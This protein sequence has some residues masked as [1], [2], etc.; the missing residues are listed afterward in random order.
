MIQDWLNRGRR[1]GARPAL[2]DGLEDDWMEQPAQDQGDC[3]P[4][5]DAELQLSIVMPC[6]NEADTIAICI[7]KAQE[8]LREHHIH[9]EIVV[10]DNG[11]TDESAKIAADLGARVVHVARKGYGNALMGGISAARG[12]YVLMGDADD[13]YDFREAP[14]FLEKLR[15][16]HELVMGCRLPSGGG[17]VRPGA[18]PFLHR[19]VGNP[20]FSLLVRWWFHAPVHDV[21]CGL[22]GFTRELVERLDLRCAGME[23]ASE[24]VIK[25]SLHRA[26]IGEVP[27]VLH[28]DGRR[29]RPPH[30]RTLKD[31]WRHLRFYLMCCPRWLY[32]GPGGLLILFGLICYLL[33][34]PGVRLNGIGFAEHTLLFGTLAI[35]CGHQALL[36]ALFTKTFAISEG[37]LPSD[38]RA[39]KILD[40]MSLERTLLVGATC[41]LAGI[42]LLVYAIIHWHSLH[43]GNMDYRFTMRRVVPGAMLTALGFQTIL[44]GFFLAILRLPHKN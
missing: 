38:E 23:Y 22:R 18:M 42:G 17:E 40:F 12:K 33:G 5:H 15:Q 3:T 44:G 7:Q 11:S 20:L 32:L 9:G 2:E 41:L 39:T 14:R 10:A 31:G 27:I 28:P 35:L 13:S 34:L 8:A 30:L 24:M 43:F 26:T 16:G 1:R 29:S 4:E 25:A 36:F 6:L 21:H 37:I 19:W